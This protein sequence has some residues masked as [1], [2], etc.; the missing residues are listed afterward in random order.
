[1]ALGLSVM[2]NAGQSCKIDG[3][4]I[5]VT[6]CSYNDGVVTV[7][8]ANDSPNNANVKVTVIVYYGTKS[9][10]YT[11]PYSTF[12]SGNN[13]GTEIKINVDPKMGNLEASSAD[14]KDITGT[15]CK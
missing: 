5:E 4:S 1:M 7:V 15:K 9:K 13:P 3:G 8:V 2:V 10:E 14:V 12:V 6:G 11:T